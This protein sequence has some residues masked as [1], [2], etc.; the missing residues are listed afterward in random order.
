MNKEKNFLDQFELIRWD[1]I[2]NMLDGLFY[3]LFGELRYG[4]KMLC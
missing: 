2:Q 4:K 1:Y 3:K